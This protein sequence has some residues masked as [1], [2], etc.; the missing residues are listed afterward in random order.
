MAE[1]ANRIATAVGDLTTSMATN[2][3]LAA[4]ALRGADEVKAAMETVG[5]AAVQLSDRAAGLREL[6]SRFKL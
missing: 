4:D 2:R 6:G 1:S 3:K 5:Q